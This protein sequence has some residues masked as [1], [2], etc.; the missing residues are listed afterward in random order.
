MV[1][2]AKIIILSPDNDSSDTDEDDSG[3]SNGI[4]DN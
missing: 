2:D 1:S 4:S 3:D